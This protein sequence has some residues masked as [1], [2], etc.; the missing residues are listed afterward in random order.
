MVGATLNATLILVSIRELA[1][2]LCKGMAMISNGMK[3]DGFKETYIKRFDD[4]KNYLVMAGCRFFQCN[5]KQ[6]LEICLIQG[7][8]AH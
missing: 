2:N 5:T 3:L 4:L 8:A 7:R 1:S 6:I